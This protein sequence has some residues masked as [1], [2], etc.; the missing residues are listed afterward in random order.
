MR[1]L[2]GFLRRKGVSSRTA[3]EKQDLVELIH[4]WALDLDAAAAADIADSKG[5]KNVRQSSER[6]PPTTGARP[7]SHSTYSATSAHL[8]INAMEQ[9]A[10]GD[11]YSGL[12]VAALRHLLHSRGY[13]SAHCIE[14]ADLVKLLVKSDEVVVEQE[15]EDPAV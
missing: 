1:E 3:L 12:D 4:G 10:S 5:M 15:Q 7:A 9:S 11:L 8:T 6:T 2:K 14:K 13:S